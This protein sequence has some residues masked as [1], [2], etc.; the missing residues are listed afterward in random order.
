MWK[1]TGWASGG[2]DDVMN[3]L[4]EKQS[5]LRLWNC[6]KILSMKREILSSVF[7]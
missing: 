5:C 4:G 6:L 7:D 3:R 2:A 1:G